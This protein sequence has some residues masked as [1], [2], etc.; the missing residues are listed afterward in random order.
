MKQMGRWDR[1]LTEY[2]FNHLRPAEKSLRALTSLE[3]KVA[4]LEEMAVGRVPFDPAKIPMKTRPQLR[5]FEDEPRGMWRWALPAVDRFDGAN[6]KLMDRYAA[7]IKSLRDF[8]SSENYQD[9]NEEPP[10]DIVQL[11]NIISALRKQNLDFLERIDRLERSLA[12]AR[13]KS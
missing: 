9:K 13:G 6:H 7:A 3:R 1:I 10:Q 12:T 2:E 11:K 5:S 4:Y 8:A